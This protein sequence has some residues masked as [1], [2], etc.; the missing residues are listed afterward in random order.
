MKE[1]RRDMSEAGLSPT[2]RKKSI[3]R[4]FW[5]QKPF[6]LMLLPGVIYY[7]VYKYVP[8]VTG[9]LVSIKEY[10]VKRGV[11]G[12]PLATPF[13]KYFKFFFDSPFFGQLLGNTLYISLCKIALGLPLAVILAILLNEC[14][15]KKLRRTVQ[16]LTY[17]PHFLSWVVIYGMCF[18][19][20]SETNGIVNDWLRS[21]TG[22][23]VPLLTAPKEFRGLVI[24]SDIWKTTGWSAIIYLAAISGI[25]P[26]LYEAAYMDGAT[27]WQTIRHITLPSI[28]TVVVMTLILRCGSVL[29]AGFDQIFVM[30]NEGVY[31][32]CDIIDTWVYRTGIENFNISLSSA[33]GLFKSFISFALVILVNAVA[34]RW[35]ESM[36]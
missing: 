7:L 33:V 5:Q 19:L 2:A 13:Y 4:R 14:R 23:T 20:F 18:V 8:I 1:V 29:N 16:T 31:S 27:R 30:Y 17:M 12:S 32:T 15:S 24:F 10:K 6:F 11:L 26:S 9:V 35:G 22:S 28:A 36:W 34:R 21:L 3:A 25:D